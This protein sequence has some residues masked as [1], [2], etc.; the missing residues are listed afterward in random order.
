MDSAFRTGPTTIDT[1]Q[2]THV[3]VCRTINCGRNASETDIYC[4]PC[5]ETIGAMR[6]TARRQFVIFGVS[7]RRVA[8]DPSH[9]RSRRQS[10]SFPPP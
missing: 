3:A 8:I 10:Q 7:G 4:G 1:T 6:D 5:R 9:R 2:T